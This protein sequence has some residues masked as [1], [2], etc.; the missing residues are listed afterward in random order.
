MKKSISKLIT[1][2]ALLGLSQQSVVDSKLQRSSMK[3][4]L[5]QKK[6]EPILV[7]L[8]PHSYNTEFMRTVDE[9]FSAEKNELMQKHFDK[10]LGNMAISLASD[11]HRTFTH[12]EVRYFSNWYYRLN[13]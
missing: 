10:V 1:V 6:D 9:Y 11:P 5:S 12:Y 13:L 2:L 4:P 3:G 7:H 8:V